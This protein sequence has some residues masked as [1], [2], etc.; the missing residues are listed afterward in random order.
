MARLQAAAGVQRLIEMGMME[1]VAGTPGAAA[2]P[3]GGAPIDA[4]ADAP[5][6]PAPVVESTVEEALPPA[7]MPAP[8]RGSPLGKFLAHFYPAP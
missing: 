7:P 4:P 6:A 8:M 2:A 5:G 1:G 3:V